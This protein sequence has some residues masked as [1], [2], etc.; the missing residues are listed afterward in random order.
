M[1]VMLRKPNKVDYM[2][3]KSYQ[4]I[5][6]FKCLEK[7]CEKM[8]AGMVADWCELHHILHEELLSSWRQQSVIDAATQMTQQV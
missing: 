5:S 4:V 3:V 2:I 7:V 6:I 8:V 1:G